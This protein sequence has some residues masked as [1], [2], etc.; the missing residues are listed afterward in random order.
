MKRSLF[1]LTVLAVV[2]IAPA[3]LAD[4]GTPTT[5]PAP[6]ASGTSTSASAEG[7]AAPK[8]EGPKESGLEFG[9]RLGYGIPL[10]DAAK[11]SKLSDTYSG[12][13]P[14]WLDVGYRIIPQVYVGAYGHFAPAFTAD[15]GCPKPA[16]CS[17]NDIRFGANVHYR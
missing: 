17:G 12:M 14:I 16:S 15:K 11:D 2:A 3:A 7:S 1:G 13:V 10:G 5:P 9:A 8:A 4:E 6:N